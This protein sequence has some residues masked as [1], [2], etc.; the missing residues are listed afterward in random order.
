MGRGSGDEYRS[1]DFPGVQSH[2]KYKGFYSVL[3]LGYG[4]TSLS[5]L[6][7]GSQKL[8]SPTIELHI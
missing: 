1:T 6:P 5:F 7:T 2:L 4:F 3:K 8:K